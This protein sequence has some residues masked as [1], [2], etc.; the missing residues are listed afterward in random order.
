MQQFLR[1][2]TAASLLQGGGNAMDYP[3]LPDEEQELREK[4]FLGQTMGAVEGI[5]NTLDW[6]GSQVRRGLHGLI[7]G[8]Y[9]R[10]PQSLTGSEGRVYGGDIIDDLGWKAPEE[11]SWANA[12]E[13]LAHGVLGFGVDVVT[14]PLS[15]V[16]PFGK[17]VQGLRK[18]EK[19]GEALKAATKAAKGAVQLTPELEEAVRLGTMTR[20]VAE[21]GMPRIAP[22]M[23]PTV[24][25]AIPMDAAGN[26]IREAIGEF[27]PQAGTIGTMGK[28]VLAGDR[29]GI[30]FHAPWWWPGSQVKKPWLEIGTGDTM[31][32]RAAAKVADAVAYNPAMSLAR[33]LLPT[34]VQGV[35]G[36][37]AQRLADDAY[38]T[39]KNL[40][41]NATASAGVFR[42]AYEDFVP[43]LEDIISHH[44]ANGDRKFADEILR[45][46]QTDEHLH[47]AES[48]LNYLAEKMPGLNRSYADIQELQN[49]LLPRMI[50]YHQN[51]RRFEDKAMKQ[52][53]ANG[54]KELELKDLFAAYAHRSV[55]LMRDK[56]SAASKLKRHGWGNVEH[57]ARPEIGRNDATRHWAGSEPAINFHSQSPETMGYTKA[58]KDA[59]LMKEYV[60]RLAEGNHSAAD[61]ILAGLDDEGKVLLELTPDSMQQ[62][63]KAAGMSNADARK[64]GELAEFAEKHNANRGLGLT[65]E[66]LDQMSGREVRGL[67]L[68]Q[69]QKNFIK[70]AFRDQ[71]DE[72]TGQ[73]R[74]TLRGTDPNDAATFGKIIKRADGTYDPWVRHIKDGEPD[75]MVADY[76]S[77]MQRIDPTTPGAKALGDEHPIQ[78]MLRFLDGF[79][80]DKLER[81]IYDQNIAQDL[82]RYVAALAE[83]TATLRTAHNWMGR[84]G[85]VAMGMKHGVPLVKA[86]EQSGLSESGLHSFIE[87]HPTVRQQYEQRLAAAVDEWRNR[88]TN[89]VGTPLSLRQQPNPMLSVDEIVPKVKAGVLK[90]LAEDLQIHPN[91]VKGLKAFADM[92]EVSNR[93]GQPG[94]IMKALDNYTTLWRT[95]QYNIWPQ[96]H[97]RDVI[98]RV[99]N[100][101]LDGRA[102]LYDILTNTPEFVK[103]LKNA[104][105]EGYE[106][107]EVIR[108]FLP[109]FK[110]YRGPYESAGA[111]ALP[112]GSPTSS[113][114]N[115]AAIPG[116]PGR[117][118]EALA[119]GASVHPWIKLGYSAQ[120]WGDFVGQGAH[121]AA[122]R[123]AGYTIEQAAE[124]VKQTHYLSEMSPFERNF[125]SKIVPFER[126]TVRNIPHQ[127]AAIAKEPGGRTAQTLR[128]MNESSAQNRGDV[129]VPEWMRERTVMPFG[130]ND[131][132]EQ[133]YYSNTSLPQSELN[134]IVL[135][136]GVVEDVGRTGEKFLS[137]SLPL[138]LSLI[139]RPW[140][141]TGVQLHTGRKIGDLEKPLKRLAEEPLIPENAG[142][143]DYAQSV[144][145]A[146]PWLVGKIPGSESL[147]HYASPG[148]R[149][150]SEGERLPGVS[151]HGTWDQ[152][153]TNVLGL[154]KVSYYDDAKWRRRDFEQGLE[155]EAA[156]KGARP[157]TN[158]SIPGAP[159][160]SRPW[161]VP[162]SVASRMTPEQLAEVKAILKR[163]EGS[164]RYNSR[165]ATEKAFQQQSSLPP[166][167]QP[168]M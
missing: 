109:H 98:S 136:K 54:G 18:V 140:S 79:G 65:Q 14:D 94:K 156:S 69:D 151:Q 11:W 73:M 97:I 107:P 77:E 66:Q 64:F 40:V 96:S 144:A 60:Q 42:S 72:T 89:A 3:P 112:K 45:G 5:A 50:D 161:I 28:D 133:G 164:H 16:S 103:Y 76:I 82:M 101:A 129:Y 93:T 88:M 100:A 74:Q 70:T 130:R 55:G 58:P 12:P 78:R 165:I 13:K 83:R 162:G 92:A 86:W 53:V 20:E 17:T 110:A 128:A 123:K 139:E 152:L 147:I 9:S 166:S 81:G 34:A 111:S 138:F 62:A 149:V 158:Y 8:D 125:L 145:K 56:E 131:K 108:E 148:A 91:A 33:S 26:P 48:A 21:A 35:W 160:Q 27:A 47:N 32:G 102:S 121:F 116:L 10:G 163:R 157:W 59:A 24:N 30:T 57:D 104:G 61:A 90:A 7:T 99:T 39:T 71:F 167:A 168:T 87:N 115:L 37:T 44:T 52:W 135:G 84:E 63:G 19:A 137:K 6:G 118:K 25:A 142:P 150:L 22:T 95:L 15:L 106:M 126:F 4:G 141:D 51:L 143:M 85:I 36:P 68:W 80:P 49:S 134:D 113:A 114:F 119:A 23:A 105:K 127:L 155:A 132:G 122:L 153:L 38:V 159:T 41:G 146:L 46:I 75:E 120:Q 2:P 31:L 1:M 124:I 29:A 67:R 154:G 43:G 117:T